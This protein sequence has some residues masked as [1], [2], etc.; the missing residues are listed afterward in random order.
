MGSAPNAAAT[1]DV[2]HP[3]KQ[4]LVQM[5]SVFI[6]TLLICT[7][8]AL[9]CLCS[10]VEPT[11][12]LGGAPYVQA[13]LS[14]NF[15]SIGPVFITVAMIL[16][17]FTTLL[18]N[19]YYCD[20][21][22]IYLMGKEPSK[23]FMTGFRVVGAIVIFIGAGLSMGVV[24]DLADVLMGIMAIINIPVIIILGTPAIKALEDYMAQKKAGKNPTFKASTV[25]LEGKVDFWK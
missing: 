17:A 20:N 6:D 11:V 21:L 25:G 14:A 16:F 23:S 13:A 3:A 15:G 18:G 12:E 22:V 10:G 8:T 9:M 19:F 1:A 24:W 5:L 2:S 7:A 4:G